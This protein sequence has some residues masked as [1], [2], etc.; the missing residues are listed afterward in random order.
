[1]LAWLTITTTPRNAAA[2]TGNA[3]GA[4][5]SLLFISKCSSL[6]GIATEIP[7]RGGAS[8]L[9][10]DFHFDLPAQR[11]IHQSEPLRASFFLPWRFITASTLHRRPF[12]LTEG[13]ETR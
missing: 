4:R 11:S 7:T 2:S 9:I 10:R 13:T 3:T 1:M 6:T 12:W 8:S 5:R